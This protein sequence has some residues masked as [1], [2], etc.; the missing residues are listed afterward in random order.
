MRRNNKRSRGTAKERGLIFFAPAGACK[1]PRT[2]PT[3]HAVGHHRT[4]LRSYIPP[5]SK[6]SKIDMYARHPALGTFL[7]GSIPRGGRLTRRGTFFRRKIQMKTRFA[8]KNKLRG[9]GRVL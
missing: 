2:V 4:L 3:A 6:C 9:R 8:E 1:F 7:L 5:F